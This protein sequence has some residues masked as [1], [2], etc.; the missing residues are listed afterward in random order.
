[1]VER[2]TCDDVHKSG[3]VDGVGDRVVLVLVVVVLVT[4]RCFRSSMFWRVFVT[5]WL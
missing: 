3:S 2:N 4:R 5:F 1:V